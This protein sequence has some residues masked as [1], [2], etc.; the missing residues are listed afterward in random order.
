VNA[1]QRTDLD[2][3]EAVHEAFI[4]FETV[5]GDLTSLA[6][7]NALI[8]TERIKLAKRRERAAEIQQVQVVEQY[9]QP[10]AD[11]SASAE[12]GD[13]PE[14][15]P[16]QPAPASV[17][18]DDGHFKRCVL[19]FTAISHARDREHTTVLVNGLASTT[20]KTEVEAYFAEVSW[21]YNFQKSV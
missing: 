2:W 18:T 9:L 5:H 3:P 17:P 19:A 4:Q 7:A 13:A 14:P 10:V 20:D 1:L 11:V 8:E 12:A 16:Q 15:T 21:S 6:S